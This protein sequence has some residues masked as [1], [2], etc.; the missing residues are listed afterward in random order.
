MKSVIR[1]FVVVSMEINGKNYFQNNLSILLAGS[2][3]D[4]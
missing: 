1:L 3:S 2:P 4:L